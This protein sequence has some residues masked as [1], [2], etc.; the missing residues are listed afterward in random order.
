MTLEELAAKLGAEFQGQADLKLTCSC[1]L[2]SLQK[3][4]LAYVT[5]SGGIGN[6]PVPA[7]LD[8]SLRKAPE[9]NVGKETAL[10]VP[11]N[12]EP[13]TGNLIFAEDPL[14][15]HV[16][17]TRLLHPPLIPARGI[18]PSAIIAD[19][20]ELAEG[21]SVG[22]NVVIGNGVKI[23]AR[24]LIHAGVVIL[25]QACIGNDCEIFPNA[26]I[27]DRC[28][29]GNRVIIQSNAVIG[30]DGHGYYQREGINLKIPQIGIVVLEDD[31]EIG[32]GTTI[33]RARFTRTVIGRGSKIDNQVQVA[34]NVTIGEQ[35]LISAQTAIGG[36]AQAGDHLILG[37]QTGVRDN[38][39][40]GSNVTL[41]ARGVITANTKDHELL[42][43]MPSRPLSEWRKIQSLI[44]RLGELFE[45]VRKLEQKKDQ[46]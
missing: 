43:G 12:Y 42:G 2:D 15:M 13:R 10:I 20:A 3:G 21:V 35:A 7:E 19:D 18:H 36:S 40:V 26:V 31:V 37:G 8:R 16:K 22:P 25:D 17:A 27:Q 23:G 11:L 41:A 46:P 34:H 44:N 6:V 28:L 38:V 29:I 30:A 9:E 1:G 39:R 33:D 32:A 4:G 14:D 24:S 45:R 5:G